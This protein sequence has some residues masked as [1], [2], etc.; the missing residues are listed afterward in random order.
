MILGLGVYLFQTA[1]SLSQ[2]YDQKLAMDAIV[3]YNNQFLE[4]ARD[5][6]AQSLISL[7]NLIKE[8]NEKNSVVSAKQVELFVNNSKI[9]V[10]NVTEEWKVNLMQAEQAN[11]ELSYQ[12]LRV[13]HNESGYI[14]SIYYKH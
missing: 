5:I 2:S 7:I 14:K 4:Y 1:G 13:E 6:N 10:G 3:A 12:Y 9:P 8:N 11:A